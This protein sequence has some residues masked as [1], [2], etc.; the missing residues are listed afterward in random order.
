MAFHKICQ[1]TLARIYKTQP[2]ITKIRTKD[3]FPLGGSVLPHPFMHDHKG[4]D[5]EKCG[6]LVLPE[7]YL[8]RSPL[9]MSKP[10]Y[11]VALD[12]PF[13]RLVR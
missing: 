6:S 12:S 11:I 2:S 13:C 10:F 7:G 3:I 4:H 5:F 8:Y 9:G 1:N